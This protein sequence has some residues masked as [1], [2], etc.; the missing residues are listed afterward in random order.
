[1]LDGETQ[2]SVDQGSGRS[3]QRRDRRRSG[4]EVLE[5]C[6]QDGPFMVKETAGGPEM[7]IDSTPQ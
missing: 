1:M 3:R 2:E 5:D 7:V 4:G 6:P